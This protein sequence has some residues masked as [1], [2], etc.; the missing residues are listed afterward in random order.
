[1]RNQIS[2]L[3]FNKKFLFSLNFQVKMIELHHETLYFLNFY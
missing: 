3:S 1:M 2:T